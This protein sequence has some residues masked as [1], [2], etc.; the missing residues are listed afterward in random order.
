[1]MRDYRI[2]LQAKNEGLSYEDVS[3]RLSLPIIAMVFT[4]FIAAFI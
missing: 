2:A 1:M 3:G 4:Q